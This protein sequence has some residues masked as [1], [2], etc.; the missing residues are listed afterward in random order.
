MGIDLIR[1]LTPSPLCD[2]LNPPLIT[3]W[4]QYTGFCCW[5]RERES[6]YIRS[7][8]WHRSNHTNTKQGP[9]SC[10]LPLNLIQGIFL[11]IFDFVQL[12]Q[13]VLMSLCFPFIISIIS[14]RKLFN[15]YWVENTSMLNGWIR[16]WLFMYKW[17]NSWCDP[18]RMFYLK[19]GP[20]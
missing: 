17:I 1:P 20:S 11:D 6:I 19:L 12:F 4:K 14:E 10:S 7:W 2:A 18:S 9:F 5:W 16:Y 15:W 13:E 8:R 3:R